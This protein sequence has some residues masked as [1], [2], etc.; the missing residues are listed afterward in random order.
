ML[1]AHILE[2]IVLRIL[3]VALGDDPYLA[4]GLDIPALLESS[5]E[6]FESRLRSNPLHRH[7]GGHTREELLKLLVAG[8]LVNGMQF[9]QILIEM[10]DALRML[11]R[12]LD[13]KSVV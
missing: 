12:P 11:L 9:H 2:Q 5:H 6:E 13:R 3:E 7:F 8:V 1:I 10:C 4:F